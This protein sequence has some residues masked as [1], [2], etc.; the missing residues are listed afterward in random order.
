MAPIVRKY[1]DEEL[2]L[3][4][5]VPSLRIGDDGVLSGGT[6]NG[7]D[8]FAQVRSKASAPPDALVGPDS[9]PTLSFTSGS[10]GRPKGVLGR[11]Y[12][13]AYYFSWM[14]ERFQLSSE[15]RFTM[16]SGIAHDPIQRDIFTPLFLGAQLLVPSRED[17][18]HEKLAEW[19]SEHK[20][21][22]THLTPAMG[23]ILV[24]G[25]SA[26]FPSLDRAFFVGDVLTTRDCR[27]LRELAVNV[28]IVN[29]YG[30]TETQ[31]AVSYYEIPSRT[32]D[33][34]YLDRLKD[35]V[36]AGKGMKN[37]QLLVVNREDRTKLCTVGQIGEIYVRAAGLAEGYKGDPALNGQ[38]FVNNWFVD[39]NVW[40]EA[41]QK[42]HK[43]ESWR[44]HYKGPRDRLYRTG[45]LGRYLESGDVECTGRVDD[46]VK[47]RGFRIEL[48]DIDSNLRQNPLIRDCKTLVRR[49]KFEEATL[50]S[51][52]VPEFNEWPQWLKAHG[53]EDIEDEGTD[54]GPTRVFSKRFRRMQ[55]EVR[56]DL[57]GRLRGAHHFYR[58]E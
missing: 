33:S 18:Q 1:I 57:K 25:A 30:T 26:T 17:I 2:H 36:P 13:L 5:E 15:S 21:T 42:N 44:K 39:N 53:L 49:D 22:V 38:K 14:A 32:K 10:E 46:Q 56:D 43:G 9:N 48:N 28:N 4:A 37:V 51:Y 6:V 41:D 58:P 3:K 27:S 45:D 19:M 40:V 12:S 47:I 35:L 7:S 55:T 54:F 20:P 29:M 11:H 50:V 31:R 23:Q 24:G 8:I 34:T 52:I 16:L